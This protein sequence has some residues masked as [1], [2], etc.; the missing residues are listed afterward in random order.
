MASASRSFDTDILQ[1][2]KVFA[3][4]PQ[5]GFIPSSHVLISNGDGSTSWN[6]VSSIVPVSS[7][8]IAYG[9]NSA[10]K[11]YANLLFNTLQISTTG[12]GNIFQSYVDPVSRALML[13]NALPPFAVSL[14]SVPAVTTAAAITTPNAQYLIPTG[15]LSTIKYFGVNDIQLSTVTTQNAI[16]VSISS[17]TSAGYS[18][19]SGETFNWRPTLYSTLSTTSG[20]ASFVSSLRVVQPVSLTTIP[21]STTGNDL[22]FSSVTFSANHL[23]RYMDNRTTASSRMFVDLEPSLFFPPL[24]QVSGGNQNVIKEISSYLELNTPTSGRVMF[25]ESIN[26]KYLTSQIINTDLSNYF[27]T[28]VRMQ[29]NPYTLQTNINL[30]SPNTVNVTVYHRI[31]NGLSNPTNP[32]FLGPVVNYDNRTSQGLYV[33]MMNNTQIYP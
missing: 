12:V 24:Y 21:M 15:T 10:N 4:T 29:I 9:N 1:V 26:T 25:Q 19:I 28:S 27:N 16:F 2:R 6:S 23:M 3:R 30:N 18:T 22:Y 14:G 13:S 33:Q 5:N 8:G 17:F 31:V 32:G 11:L 20:M 7:F